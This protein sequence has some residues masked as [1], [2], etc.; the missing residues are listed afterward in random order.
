MHS[1][2]RPRHRAS[3]CW[4][5]SPDRRPLV[6]PPAVGQEIV[7]NVP[8]LGTRSEHLTQSVVGTF[9]PYPKIRARGQMAQLKT[10]VDRRVDR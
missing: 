1:I 3:F 6:G 4:A 2:R 7:T 5:R 9:A 8:S 10:F